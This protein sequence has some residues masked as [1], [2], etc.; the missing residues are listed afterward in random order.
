MSQLFAAAADVPRIHTAHTRSKSGAQQ[1]DGQLCDHRLPSCGLDSRFLRPAGSLQRGV[2]RVS[3]AW[4]GAAGYL[5]RRS[6]V[7]RSVC[8]SAPVAFSAARRL[9]SERCGGQQLRRLS[10]SRRRRRARGVVAL[11]VPVTPRDHILRPAPA[12]V[13]LVDYECSHWGAAN[14]IVKLVLE[15][16]GRNARYVFRHV[17]LSQ[18]HPRAEAAAAWRR[19]RI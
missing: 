3:Q 1:I 13:T 9:S 4:R 14:P 2:A 8:S 16:L 11:K 12:P 19:K 18:V 15:H 17:P 5:G 6:L 10:R 7:S